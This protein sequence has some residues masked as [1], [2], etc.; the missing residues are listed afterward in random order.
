MLKGVLRW[1]LVVT[2]MTV[3]GRHPRLAA[4]LDLNDCHTWG[5][6]WGLVL[7]EDLRHGHALL[8]KRPNVFVH[9]P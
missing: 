5:W 3:R 4:T 9:A 8:G 6:L 7:I 1:L 2:P